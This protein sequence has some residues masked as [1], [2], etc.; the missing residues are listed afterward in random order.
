MKKALFTNI[1]KTMAV[2]VAAAVSAAS[3]ADFALAT[4]AVMLVPPCGDYSVTWAQLPVR[5]TGV[6]VSAGSV[7]RNGRQAIVAAHAGVM[8]NSVVATYYSGGAAI[9]WAAMTNL[10][11]TGGTV[12]TNYAVAPIS[13]PATGLS[14]Y[15]G[16]VRWH[17]VRPMG[18]DYVRLQI[19]V[20]GGVVTLADS[21]GDSVAYS[22]TAEKDF[23]GFAG[24]LYGSMSAG[25]N[26]VK[27]LVW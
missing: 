15:D 6:A 22:S 13:V 23:P 16:T 14:G 12:V 8:T 10:A 25:T 21:A 3:A 9:S 27:A 5:G 24:A 4:N 1:I 2:A 18:K 26:S 7:Y 11:A 19:T 17:Q 20:S